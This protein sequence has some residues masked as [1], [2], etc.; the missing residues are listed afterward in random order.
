MG[1]QPTKVRS[2]LEMLRGAPIEVWNKTEARWV[3]AVIGSPKDVREVPPD[4]TAILVLYQEAVRGRT[5]A[6]KWIRQEDIPQ[7]I[8]ARPE[9]KKQAGMMDSMV[10]SFGTMFDNRSTFDARPAVPQAASMQSAQSMQSI[11]VERPQVAPQPGGAM[12]SVMAAVGLAPGPSMPAA[13]FASTVDQDSLGMRGNFQRG[14]SMAST[15]PENN[16]GFMESMMASM[17]PNSGPQY[18]PNVHSAAMRSH[19]APAPMSSLMQSQTGGAMSS[20]VAHQ[21]GAMSSQMAQQ[22]N[23][24]VMAS[25]MGMGPVTGSAMGSHYAGSFPASMVLDENRSPNRTPMGSVKGDAFGSY[26]GSAPSAVVKPEPGPMSSMMSTIFAMPAQ[27]AG[28]S[29]M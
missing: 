2:S 14:T 13:S 28:R 6:Y 17:A 4:D 29:H 26:A 18:N 9:C 3:K 27:H 10:E 21:G 19:A 1:A 20:Q 5:D 23:A 16:I 25:L 8:R 11:P 22:S 12:S 7:L 15:V 24:G